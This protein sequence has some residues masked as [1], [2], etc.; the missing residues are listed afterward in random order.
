MDKW[1]ALVRAKL[2]EL[3]LT[4]EK[5]GERVGVS[6]GGVGHWLNKRRQP[7][8]ETMNKVFLAL[9]L[10]HLEIALVI[11]DRSVAVQAPAERDGQLYDT[12]SAF[13]YPVSD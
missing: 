8:L 6:Q 9:G 5:L 11:R 12:T 10:G 7:D 1:I 4:Q 13:R 3:D 2:R